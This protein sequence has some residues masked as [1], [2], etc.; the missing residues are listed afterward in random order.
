[1]HYLGPSQNLAKFSPLCYA[2]NDVL[3]LSLKI[4]WCSCRLCEGRRNGGDKIFALPPIPFG[5]EP[6][7]W[8]N[9]GE[10][11]F[12]WKNEFQIFFHTKVHIFRLAETFGIQGNKKRAVV[13]SVIRG[14]KSLWYNYLILLINDDIIFMF[15]LLFGAFSKINCF[16]IPLCVTHID[17]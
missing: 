15:Q 6:E 17:Q 8:G 16:P 7:F 12:G 11:L 1:M 3:T 2:Q 5:R 9:F 4:F 13:R 10:A 14:S